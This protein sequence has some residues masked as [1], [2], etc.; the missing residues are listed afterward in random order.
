M[1]QSI[2]AK[3]MTILVNLTKSFSALQIDERDVK[4]KAVRKIEAN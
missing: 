2:Y 4:K 3:Q 1:P